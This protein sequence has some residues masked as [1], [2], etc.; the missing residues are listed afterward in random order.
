MASY[1]GEKY[2]SQQIESIIN[3]SYANWILFIRDD[4][5]FDNTLAIIKNYSDNDCRIKIIDNNNIRFGACL[6]FGELIKY[7]LQYD[8]NYIMFADQDDVWNTN[9]IEISLSSFKKV[10]QEEASLPILLHTDFQYVDEALKNIHTRHNIAKNFAMYKNK[11]NIIINDNYVFGCT[12]IL[13][14]TLLSICSPIPKQAINHDHWIA[15]HAA[16]FGRI[17]YLDKKTM[18]YRQHRNNVTGGLKYS[19]FRNR[20][21]RLMN[22][23]VYIKYKRISL[24]Q[25][26][27][28]VKARIGSLSD[29]QLLLFRKYIRCIEKGGI[30][31]VVFLL[32]NGFRLRGFFQ[33]FIFYLSVLVDRDKNHYLIALICLVIW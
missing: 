3:Q 7:I 26:D 18:L 21:R 9:K 25:F 4:C 15:L 12:S 22:F 14:R 30:S 33:T 24:I 23:Q 29:Q 19:Y 1:N 6:N 2:I 20:L 13:N 17:V 10:E 8:Y 32:S 28:F 16:A 27:A 5:S 11:I 31:A